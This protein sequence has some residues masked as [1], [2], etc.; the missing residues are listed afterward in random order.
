[1]PGAIRG[2]NGATPPRNT[3][4]CQRKWTERGRHHHCAVGFTEKL[5]L[6]EVPISYIRLACGG[7]KSTAICITPAQIETILAEWRG[8]RSK[9]NALRVFDVAAP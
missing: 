4:G 5:G 2:K 9:F 6:F 7:T 8:E 3:V 1:M